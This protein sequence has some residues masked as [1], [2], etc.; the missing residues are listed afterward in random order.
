MHLV[1]VGWAITSLTSSPTVVSLA[2]A[3]W[4][5]P[6]FLLALLAGAFAD[7]VDR[8]R[9]IVVTQACSML[10]AGA[11][12]A[13][14]FSGRLTVAELLVLTFLLSSAMTMSAPAFMALT[15]ELVERDQLPAAIGLNSIS[16]NIAQSFGPALAGLVIAASGPGAVFVVNAAS[17]LGIV[18]VVRAYR[19]ADSVTLPAEHIVAAMR[20]GAAYFMNSPRL[21]VLAA[22]VVLAL[23]ATSALSALLPII[24]RTQLH[25]SAGQFGLLSTAMGV[26]AVVAVWLLPRVNRRTTPDAVV[27]GAS[28]AWAAGA[29][30][31]ASAHSLPIGLVGLALAG[32]GTMATM[33]VVFSMYTTMLP[34]WVRGRASSVAMLVIWLGA[35]VGAVGWGTLGSAVGV[36]SAQVI[37]ALAHIVVTVIASIVLRL[38]SREAPDITPVAW[39]MP[40]LQVPPGSADGPVLRSL[41]ID[42]GP[43]VRH[44]ITH[45]TRS[46]GPKR[47]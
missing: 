42:D 28:A 13:L 9:L 40:E 36:R 44:L 35:S 2:Q 26:G 38:G 45:T 32:A 39:A 11:L 20:T 37:A 3:A 14:E 1:A 29:A 4:T 43:H 15:P 24:A 41:V 6:G 27:I 17:F 34:A 10:C 47:R 7:V 33:N 5:I 18:V 23:T 30:T 46:S 16:S 25:A 22:R 19:A 21:Q 8:R 12:G 31:F